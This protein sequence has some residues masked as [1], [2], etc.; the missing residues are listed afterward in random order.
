[1]TSVVNYAIKGAYDSGD[2]AV[3]VGNTYAKTT[4]IGEPYTFEVLANGMSAVAHLWQTSGGVYVG[5]FT[6]SQT[7][8]SLS[9]S[10]ANSTYIYAGGA[11]SSGNY[12]IVAKRRHN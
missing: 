11:Q 9:I 1:V 7:N 6:T 4:N 5:T 3:A 2:F 8:N 10:L 12:R